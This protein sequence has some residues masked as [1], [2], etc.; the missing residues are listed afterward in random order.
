MQESAVNRASVEVWERIISFVMYNV[1]LYEPTLVRPA[2][3]DRDHYHDLEIQRKD[4]A[5][6]CRGWYSHII[7]AYRIPSPTIHSDGKSRITFRN[8]PYPRTAY[9]KITK[10]DPDDLSECIRQYPQLYT[11]CV[12]LWGH[13]VLPL[14]LWEQFATLSSLTHLTHLT[15][16]SERG[17]SDI[18][19]N[20]PLL[21]F[22]KLYFLDFRVDVNESCEILQ[23][24]QAPR[25]E[26]FCLTIEAEYVEKITI[27][28]ILRRLGA[29][30]RTFVGRDVTPDPT[31][32]KS[33]MI[34]P[35]LW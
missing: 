21:H 32:D 12:N 34:A 2:S 9:A 17:D 33:F 30:L 15:F 3:V 6:V 5:L 8:H 25:L 29:K 7:E 1:D 13:E 14:N 26:E 11:V 23:S 20:P 24:I 31:L 10:V 16:D 19:A 28:Q 22:P 35:E 27:P 18:P 4:L